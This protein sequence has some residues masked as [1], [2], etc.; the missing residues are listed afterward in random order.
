VASHAYADGPLEFC[1]NIE[2]DECRT[3]GSLAVTLYSLSGSKLVNADTV[4]LGQSISLQ[5]GRN[6]VKLRIHKLY[7][8]P[9]VYVVGFW[10]ANPIS[11]RRSGGEYDH[12]QSA[13]EIDVVE[14]SSV[15]LGSRSKSDG[16]VTCH[17]DVVDAA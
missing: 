11:A 5:K 17:F 16:V 2:S 7:L 15:R 10:L 12:V 1:L 14:Y 13:F 3:V 8:N 6:L 9:G 4:S